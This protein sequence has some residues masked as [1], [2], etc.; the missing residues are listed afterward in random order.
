MYQI[1]GERWVEALQLFRGTWCKHRRDAISTLDFAMVISCFFFSMGFNH[2]NFF[3]IGTWEYRNGWDKVVVTGT[4]EIY[5]F[6]IIL[7]M[8]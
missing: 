5:D 8:E 6:P 1:P 7:G 4:M 3:F 2:W